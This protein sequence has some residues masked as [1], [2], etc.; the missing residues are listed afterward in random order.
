MTSFFRSENVVN[1]EDVVAVF[2]VVTVVLEAL[3]GLGEHS[4]WVARRL[5]FEVRVADAVCRGQV[6]SKRLE[7]LYATQSLINDHNV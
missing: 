3:A 6:N 4:P 1:I 2:I 7:G 5:V